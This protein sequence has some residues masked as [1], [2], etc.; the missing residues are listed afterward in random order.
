MRVPSLGL[1]QW[2]EDRA[3]HKLWCRSRRSLGSGVAMTMAEAGNSSSYPLTQELPCAAGAALKKQLK[4]T[5]VLWEVSIDTTTSENCLCYIL[6]SKN[7]ILCK[8]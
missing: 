6:N 4:N 5:Y 3:F 7:Q 2:V 8:S 1:I